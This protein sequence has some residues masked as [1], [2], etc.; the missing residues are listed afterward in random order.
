MTVVLSP[1]NAVRNQ[2][3]RIP[4]HLSIGTAGGTHQVRVRLANS[5]GKTPVTFD[6]A[7]VALQDSTVGGATAASVPIPLTFDGARSV[8]L[9]AG[10]DVISDPVTLTVP[11]RAMALVSLKVPGSLTTLAGH[12]DARTP[13]YVSATDNVDHTGEQAGAGFAPSKMVGSPFLSGIDVTTPAA[14]PAGSLVLFGDQTVN[15]D[16]AGA[17]GRSQ[18]DSQLAD[19][20]AADENTGH[21]VP[22][23]VLNLG[24]SSWGNGAKLP[25]GN[26]VLP[27][28][29]IASVDRAILNQANVRT[30]LISAGSSDLLAC[31]AATAEACATPVKNK[32][33]ALAAQLRRFRT[34][35]APNPPGR[36]GALKIYAATLPP[37]HSSYTATQEAAREQVNNYI[38]GT[39]GAD[40]LQGYADGVINFAAAVSSDGNHTSDTILSDYMWMD[41][42]RQ[43]PSNLYYQALAQQYLLDADPSDWVT[44]DHSGGTEPDADPVGVWKFDEGTGATAIDTGYGT[45]AARTTHDAALHQVGWGPGRLVDRQAGTF[46][47]TSSYAGT[48][49]KTNTTKS[50]TVSAWVRLTDKSAD[51]TIFSRDSD[52]YGSLYFRYQKATDRWVAQMPSATSGDAVN[53]HDALSS[54]PAQTGLW[55]HLAAAYDAELRSLTLYVNGDADTS[56]EEVTPFNDPGGA[57]WIGRSDDTWFAGDIADVRVWA[58]ATNAAETAEEAAATLVADWQFEDDSNPAV[59]KDSSVEENDGALTGGAGYTYPGHTDWDIGAVRLNGTGAAVTSAKLLR[60]DQSFSVAAWVRLTKTAGDY[61]VVSQEGVHASRFKVEWGASCACWRFTGAHTDEAVPAT[62]QASAPTGTTLN[63]WTHVAGVYDAAAG[64]M[65]IYVNGEP[66]QSTTAVAV[67][68][69]ATGPFAAGRA[70]G[71]DGAT[72]WFPGDIDAVRVYQGVASADLIRELSAS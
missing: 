60:T 65:T 44:E 4:A 67:P 18:L 22:F 13:I 40:R 32:L 25:T 20:L 46:N 33:V 34:D 17:D 59:A 69:N 35:D 21:T 9:A 53:W 3:V 52:G 23:G 28:S 5:L 58:R 38:L 19:A 61:T 39:D 30:V 54:A 71:E 12:Q 55:T 57:T 14:S 56:I 10:T 42:T 47:G 8:T 48:D 36:T 29:A 15:S 50:F 11:E 49:L 16:T 63:T 70:R 37:F 26:A 62:T 43:Y 1:V 41:G 31:T 6:A 27:E 45:G 68:W 72:D 24:S 7:S 2:T 51:R 64:T 66:A